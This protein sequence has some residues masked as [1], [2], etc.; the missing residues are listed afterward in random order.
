MTCAP[1]FSLARRSRVV[2]ERMRGLS[3]LTASSSSFAATVAPSV[4]IV[5]ATAVARARVSGVRAV[6]S[7]ADRDSM[8]GVGPSCAAPMP[9]SATRPA[10]YG[11]SAALGYHHL[12]RAGPGGRRRRARAAVVHDG[13]HPA[14]QRL[15]VDLA[16]DEAVVPVVDQ[17]QVG[18]AAGDEHAAALRADRL[19]GHPGDVLRGAHGHAAE[20]HVHRWRAGVQERHQLGRERAFVRQDPRAGLHDVEVRRLL[21]RV[22]DRVRRQPRPVGEDVVAD[23]VHRRQADRRPV[24]VDRRAEQRVDALG[25]QV[26]QHPVVGHLRRERPARLRERRVVRRRQDELAGRSR[27]RS[28]CP[29]SRP[30]TAR[31]PRPATRRSPPARHI[32]R[33]PRRPCRTGG[34]QLGRAPGQSAAAAASHRGHQ[35]AHRLA[36]RHQRHA[37]PGQQLRELLVRRRAHP[38]L[39]AECPQLHR[40]SHHRFDVAARPIRRQQHTHFATPISAVLASAGILRHD[41]GLAA[42]PPVRYMLR[43]EGVGTLLPFFIRCGRTPP[44]ESGGGHQGRSALL[45]Q[46]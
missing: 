7:A 45:R 16:D 44:R 8:V 1:Y 29:V 23:V 27:T 43:V 11:W 24:G 33:P 35:R 37:D 6:L 32:P 18:P 31:R 17:G 15:L 12:R 42:S 14:E 25:V 39:R 30:P 10:Q 4:R 2:H 38:H 21:P 22:Q 26:P 13:G 19:D 20:A 40:E 41:P 36:D 3:R 34:D 46:T 9:R 28:G 5:P